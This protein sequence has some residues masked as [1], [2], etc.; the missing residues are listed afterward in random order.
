MVTKYN[1]S[2]ISR[3][4]SYES[5]HTL[6]TLP[7]HYPAQSSTRTKVDVTSLTFILRNN[8]FYHET[9]M[10]SP[11]QY[12]KG[13]ACRCIATKFQNLTNTS[14]IAPFTRPCDS[15]FMTNNSISLIGNFVSSEISAKVNCL[16]LDGLLNVI[17][18]ETTIV[19]QFNTSHFIRTSIKHSREI[20]CLRKS[21]CAA[22][23]AIVAH[24]LFMLSNLL[25][26]PELK[27]HSKSTSQEFSVTFKVSRTGC[28]KSSPKL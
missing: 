5:V 21:S 11:L 9:K 8:V 28:A 13:Y 27:A 16:L 25:I 24:F 17:C 2:P 23:S 22:R 4:C 20:F 19:V 18:T 12:G 3:R 15:A 1:S 26:S 6:Q 7:R 14:S 10:F